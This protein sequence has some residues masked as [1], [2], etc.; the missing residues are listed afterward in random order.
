MSEI[1]SVFG[2]NLPVATLFQEGTIE[3]LATLLRAGE[4]AHHSHLIAMQPNGTRPPFF[5]IH[6]SG[7][8]VL[9]YIELARE[10]G[11]DQPFYAIES[12]ELDGRHEVCDRLEEMAA[13]YIEMIRDVQPHGPYFLGGWSMGGVVAY[14]AARQLIAAGE[15]VALV[16]LIDSFLLKPQETLPDP[17]EELQAF[18]GE[19]IWHVFGKQVPVSE[20]ALKNLEP[21][22]RLKYIWEQARLSNA[23]PADVKLSDLRRLVDVFQTNVRALRG[24]TPKSYPERVVLLRASEHDPKTIQDVSVDWGEVVRDGLERYTIPGNHFSI[25]RSPHVQLL[26]KQLRLCLED[27]QGVV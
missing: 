18:I 16:A 10:L 19:L 15:K 2:R 26:S 20:E 4:D 25:M 7:G 6:P 23:I 9:C 21:D 12:P 17:G 14:E 13:R 3:R 24:Y 27:A 11:Y 22:E 8:G 1:Q 5:C